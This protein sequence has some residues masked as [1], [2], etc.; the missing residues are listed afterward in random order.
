MVATVVGSVSEAPDTTPGPSARRYANN[1]LRKT[2]L[3][4]ANPLLIR[5]AG[6]IHRLTGHT[7]AMAVEGG[8]V[9]AHSALTALLAQ[10]GGGGLEAVSRMLDTAAF[11]VAIFDRAG[12]EMRIAYLNAAAASR[13]SVPGAAAVGRP[14]AEA[15]PRV[16]VGFLAGLLERSARERAPVNLRGLRP[17]GAAWTIDAIA[18]EPD[19]LLVMGEELGEAVSGRRRLEA[20]LGS[21]DAIWRPTDFGSMAQHIVEEAQRLV[22]GTDVVLGAADAAAPGT[23]K[24]VAASGRWSEIAGRTFDEGTVASRVA[25]SGEPVELSLPSPEVVVAPDLQPDSP[26]SVRVV[27]L[28]AGARLPDGRTSLGVLGF[29]RAGAEPFTNPERDMMD[30]FAKLVS[31]AAH[32]AELL[33]DARSSA[34][35]LQLTLDLAMALASS[36]SPRTVIQL[37][38]SRTLDAVRADRATLSRI[39]AGELVIEATYS[40]SG[41]LTWV[42]RRYSLEWLDA[43]PLVRQAVETGRPVLGGRLDAAAAAPEFRDAL[44]QVTHTATLPLVLGGDVV[45]TLVVSRVDDTAFD[46]GDLS[47]LE[48]MG[49]AAMLA[50]RNA[51]LVED[52]QTANAA[53]SEFLNLA[54]HELRTPVTVISGYT[55][56][57]QAGAIDT[58]A[59]QANAL[60]VI[61]DK[62]G[63][64]ARLVDSLLMTAR[65]QTPST[66]VEREAFDVAL[67][68]RA[69]AERARP[70]AGLAGGSIEVKLPRDQVEALGEPT[71]V[72]RVLDNLLNNAIAYSEGEPRV[73]VTLA[74]DARH[75]DVDVA[76]DGRGIP[77]S[78]HA[79]VFDEFVRL[80]D[81]SGRGGAGLGLYIARRL[82][83][84]M[85]GDL[86]L[87]RS[88]PG[89]G[90]VFRLRLARS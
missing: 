88:A 82:A 73:V 40:R 52:L 83:R 45:G 53:K 3:V 6:P 59:G 55:S 90:S 26:S 51:R 80:D 4:L 56:M 86:T 8:G 22:A 14:A 29:V 85:G 21:M 61:E 84:G 25:A 39:E 16:D 70:F 89:D 64:L 44:S 87:V 54:A 38:L 69:A 23:L 46:P 11:P 28:T 41:E 72:G 1:R 7:G 43:Q 74:V 12:G 58:A 15:F 71:L 34:H 18:L 19:R 2:L 81:G 42:G 36:N 66:R 78:H 33:A 67:A 50:L 17:G 27:P 32:R 57:L 65:L 60:K 10:L 75:V 35:R 20:L 68:V 30:E 5:V 37:L 47:V 63:E 31:L 62:A 48:L 49:N 13:A 77:P 9:S 24:L 76:D 79:S